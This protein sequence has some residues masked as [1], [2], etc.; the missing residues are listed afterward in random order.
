MVLCFGIKASTPRILLMEWG[1]RGW[2]GYSI[3]YYQNYQ[4]NLHPIY[5]VFLI[6]QLIK[7]VLKLIYNYSINKISMPLRN[8]PEDTQDFSIVSLKL[9]TAPKDFLSLIIIFFF[10]FFYNLYISKLIKNP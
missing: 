1:R 3:H 6:N 4:K 2:I 8:E 10:N 5:I 7:D 9:T